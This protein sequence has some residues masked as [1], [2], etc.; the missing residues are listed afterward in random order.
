[1]KVKK[2]YIDYILSYDN[3]LNSVGAKT[4]GKN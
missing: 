1:M 2:I 3:E 4:N